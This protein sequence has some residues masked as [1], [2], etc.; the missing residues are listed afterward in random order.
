MEAVL[1]SISA[2][3]T[4]IVASAAL[5]L[6]ASIARAAAL[7]RSGFLFGLPDRIS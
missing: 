7:A 3:R 2:A 5:S 6:S 1:E 4:A